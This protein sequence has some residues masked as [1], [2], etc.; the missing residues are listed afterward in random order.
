MENNNY[1]ILL[2]DDEPDIVEFLGYNLRRDGFTVH[3]C[4]NGKDAIDS[5]IEHLPHLIILDI[6]M[7]GIDGIEA[8]R[9][10]RSVDS[11]KHTI[12]TF[13]TARGEDYKQ[14]EGFDAGADDYIRKPISPRVLVARIKALLKRFE[15]SQKSD[16]RLIIHLNDLMMDRERFVVEKTGKNIS[17]SRKEFDLLFMLTSRPDKVFTRDEIFEQVWG[18]DVIVGERTIDVHIHKIREKIGIDAIR[19]I[20]GVGYCYT[21][22]S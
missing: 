6:M 5:A 10:I 2:V 19:T 8:C 9:A 14:I 16:K 22:A 3:T 17:M 20:K 7:P 21:L 18:N 13:L 1:S 12:I 4:N 15:Q 11:L